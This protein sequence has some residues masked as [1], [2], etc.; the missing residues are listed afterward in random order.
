M[1]SVLLALAVPETS[2]AEFCEHRHDETHRDPLVAASC[3]RRERPALAPSLSRS[4]VLRDGDGGDDRLRSRVR[5]VGN[6]V[7]GGGARPG[8]DG[9]DVD[10]GGLYPGSTP[11][12]SR[13]GRVQR[14]G[15]P[16]LRLQRSAADPM[17]RRG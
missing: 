4:T 15:R 5:G 8:H 17:S 14:R 2:A 10:L 16:R 7:R 1:P 11:T 3:E 6:A 12:E 9:S 13:I